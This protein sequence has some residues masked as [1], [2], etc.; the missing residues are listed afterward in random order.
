MA[1]ERKTARPRANEERA[2][3]PQQALK[4]TCQTVIGRAPYPR[5]SLPPR[6][7]VVLW[8]LRSVAIL[9]G[10]PNLGLRFLLRDP[11]AQD[12]ADF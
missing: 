6:A 5:K 8:T 7:D 12:Q 1:I 11:A 4:P 9:R 2:G 10:F 3:I